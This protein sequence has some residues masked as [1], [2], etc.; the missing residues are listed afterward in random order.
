MEQ[1]QLFDKTFTLTKITAYSLSLEIDYT[2][3]AYTIV[4]HIRHRFVALF[5]K[6]FEH[7]LNNENFLNT[8]EQQIKNDQ[9]L[10][11]HYKEVNFI[12]PSNKFLLIPQEFFSKK[13]LKLY[14]QTGNELAEGEEIQF[15]FIPEVN[16]YLAFAISSEVTNFFVY[17]FPEINFYHQGIPLIRKY[18]KFSQ[19]FSTPL[20]G[21]NIRKK[22]L[23]DILIMSEGK[24]LFYNIFKC[25]GEDNAIYTI[26]RVLKDFGYN[27]QVELMGDISKDD[28]IYKTLDQYLPNLNF[29]DVQNKYTVEFDQPVET[30]RFVNLFY[31]PE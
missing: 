27:S 30:H 24:L 16:T 18:A 23:M 3:M 6:K 14:F 28:K 4:D 2:H 20:I 17:R 21:I 22:S 31:I 15:N 7:P 19:K 26:M 5:Y 12:Y 10:Q 9:Y 13:D 25:L 1:I 8:I 29:A 11:K